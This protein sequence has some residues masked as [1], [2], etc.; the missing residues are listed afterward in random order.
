MKIVSIHYVV[1]A[2]FF[3]ELMELAK[4]I[5][6]QTDLAH[7]NPY[8]IALKNFGRKHLEDEK[9]K[10]DWLVCDQYWILS[11]FHDFRF[12]FQILI[13][14]VDVHIEIRKDGIKLNLSK[15]EKLYEDWIISMHNQYDEEIDSGKDEPIFV[16]NPSN[17]KELGISSDGKPGNIF[18]SAY[19]ILLNTAHL[20]NWRYLS[21]W[22]FHFF[23]FLEFIC[24]N[25]YY[26]NIQL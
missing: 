8:T 2:Y 11:F 15:L 6:F 17:K 1:H 19:Y 7:Q 22:L 9:G 13:F 14:S 18:S 24:F 3:F 16:V 23:P 26:F 12:D 21:N 20:I 5:V 4:C 10:T 25:W